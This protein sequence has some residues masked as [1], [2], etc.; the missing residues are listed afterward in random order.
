MADPPTRPK[1]PPGSPGAGVASPGLG[2]AGVGYGSSGSAAAWPAIPSAPP[3]M[4]TPATAILKVLAGRV[5][6]CRSVMNPSCPLWWR[7]HGLLTGAARERRTRLASKASA[8]PCAASP[9]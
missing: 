2:G 7:P 4:I 3:A 5:A 8:F 1:T 6:R 9:C